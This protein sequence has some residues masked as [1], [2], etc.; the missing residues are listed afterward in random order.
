M[1]AAICQSFG[2]DITIED[3]EEPNPGPGEVFLKVAAAS[4]NFADTLLLKNRYQFTPPEP[5]SPGMEVAG[6]IE[7]LGE[8]VT[9]F[10]IGQRVLS[11][12]RWN[13]C[14]EKTIA[15]ADML[16]PIPEEVSNEIASG[17]TVT[18]GT[19]IHGL[20]DRANLK[21]K[22]TLVVIGAAG[23]AGLAAVEMGRMMDAHVIAVAST[24]EK[25]ATCIDHGAD[26]AMCIGEED[27]P[28]DLKDWLKDATEGRGVDVIY[29]CVGGELAEPALR[30]MAWEGRFLVV[31]FAS[32]TIPKIPA[33]LMLLKGCDM[34][35]VF[36]S[37]FVHRETAKQ[38]ANM[39][40]VLEWCASGELEPRIH[41]V[42]PLEQT[43]DALNVITD[44][45]AVGK[46]VVAP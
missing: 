46:V 14:R 38:N 6:T 5:F 32:G 43:A 28:K 16:V 44:R 23:G 42:F 26:E 10:S 37:D 33:N 36:W 18:Y 20:R 27:D 19:A 4:L 31:G 40:Q 3:I 15:P 7:A 29:D 35:G 8:G 1:K 24:E 45:R 22:E 25:C 21:P 9:G 39:Q 34:L 11:Y 2:A 12:I 17:I 41:G 13:G 30:A